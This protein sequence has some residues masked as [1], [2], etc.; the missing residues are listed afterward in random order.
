M[1]IEYQQHLRMLQEQTERRMR[2]YEKAYKQQL[3]QL[4]LQHQ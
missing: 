1:E 4:T 3:E 2:E